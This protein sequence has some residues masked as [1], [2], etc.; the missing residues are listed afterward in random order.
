MPRAPHGLDLRD[1]PAA[2][3]IGIVHDVDP[4]GGEAP[5]RGVVVAGRLEPVERQRPVPQIDRRDVMGREQRLELGPIDGEP[6][7]HPECR[8][9]ER[10]PDAL[11]IREIRPVRGY[12]LGQRGQHVL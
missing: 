6:A 5:E 4:F 9:G 3:Q 2:L 12:Q 8:F 11:D 1:G 7:M 10:E